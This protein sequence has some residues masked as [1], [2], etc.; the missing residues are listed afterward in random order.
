[1][2]VATSLEESKLYRQQG[3]I[4]A[5]TQIKEYAVADI[6]GNMTTFEKDAFKSFGIVGS[7]V[8]QKIGSL[9]NEKYAQFMSDFF[10]TVGHG[11]GKT[12][13][14]S[15]NIGLT[16]EYFL[17]GQAMVIGIS[18]LKQHNQMA[19]SLVIG[20][21]TLNIIFA[22]R[23]GL[24]GQDEVDESEMEMIERRATINESENLVDRTSIQRS[25]STD[26]LV[27]RRASMSEHTDE[28]SNPFTKPT[29]R[30]ITFPK[31]KAYQRKMGKIVFLGCAGFA[32]GVQQMGW[33]DN[34]SLNK[35]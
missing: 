2:N 34:L 8:G 17:G 12:L 4:G 20:S 7:K 18:D 9:L 19:G 24:F 27:G 10:G 13:E 29:R 28:F 32:I 22:G 26:F 25:S 21:S 30:M 31:L 35:N 15:R 23:E 5:A 11:I 6:F 33:F 16:S 14:L 1:M 3:N